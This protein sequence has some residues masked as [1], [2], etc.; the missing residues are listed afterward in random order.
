MGNMRLPIQR[1]FAGDISSR[2]VEA[3]AERNRVVL[4]LESD[5]YLQFRHYFFSA[6]GSALNPVLLMASRNCC[7]FACVSS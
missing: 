7:S 3:V 5:A 4:F 2:I 6:L 1:E